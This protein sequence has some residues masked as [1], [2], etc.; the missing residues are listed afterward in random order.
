MWGPRRARYDLLYHHHPPIA[1]DAT[2]GLPLTPLSLQGRGDL[3]IDVTNT[4][5]LNRH[6]PECEY[7]DR[8]RADAEA[9]DDLSLLQ[10]LSP[11]DIE[12]QNKKG[13][14]TVTQLSH[15]FRPGRF[16]M[17]TQ[18]GSRRHDPALQALAV[19]EDTVYVAP[20]ARGEGVGGVSDTD[21]RT[22]ARDVRDGCGELSAV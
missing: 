3:G 19:R 10:G 9:R 2:N 1:Y 13:I 18:K 20:E 11:F 8:C 16:R 15:T 14:F 7:R 17:R 5:I 21:Q 12:H 22:D 4:A 6:C